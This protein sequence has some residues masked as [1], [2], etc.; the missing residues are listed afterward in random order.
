M[1]NVKVLD[2]DD[3]VL[4]DSS[5]EEHELSKAKLKSVVVKVK[6]VA[7]GRASSSAAKETPKAETKAADDKPKRVTASSNGGVS[8]TQRMRELICGDLSAKKEDIAALLKK[9]SLEFKQATLDLIYSDSHKLI[10]ILRDLK[11]LK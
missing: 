6:A 3:L 11:K 8:A 5:G 1:G 10:G 7:G 2:G 4:V 9:E